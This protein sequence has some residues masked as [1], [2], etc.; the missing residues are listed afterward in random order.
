MNCKYRLGDIV[1][2]PFNVGNIPTLHPCV[3]KLVGLH[4]SPYAYVISCI[5][6]NRHK[7]I[8]T[9]ELVPINLT[10]KMLAPFGF[11]KGCDRNTFSHI[12]FVKRHVIHIDWQ[13]QSVKIFKASH[14]ALDFVYVDNV[15]E[16]QHIM[17]DWFD[18]DIEPK[19]LAPYLPVRKIPNLHGTVND[20]NS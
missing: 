13:D 17:A 10:Q 18:M 11:R 20:V 16:L 5:D 6:S 7:C 12:D 14:I 3:I 9:S 8:K 15:H 19:I 1:Y 4:L 2:C